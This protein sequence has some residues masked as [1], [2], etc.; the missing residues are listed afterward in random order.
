M[1]TALAGVCEVMTHELLI[2]PNTVLSL[3]IPF[4]GFQPVAWGNVEFLECGHG[5]KLI[6]FAGGDLPQRL[7]TRAA[8]GFCPPPVEDILRTR[9]LE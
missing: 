8:G 4:Q 6:E 7:W 9:G 2:N 5:V 3:S 1:D